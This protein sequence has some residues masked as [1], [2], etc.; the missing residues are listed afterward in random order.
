MVITQQNLT[1]ANK[2]GAG[3]LFVDPTN[4][5]NT[6]NINQQRLKRKA[7][8]DTV[9]VTRLEAS[10]V[11]NYKMDVCGDSCAVNQQDSGFFRI[12]GASREQMRLIWE[13]MKINGDRLFDINADAGVPISIGETDFAIVTEWSADGGE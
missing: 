12:S 13:T 5:D 8:K 1:F 11:K 2:N 3:V 6:L 4:V 10:V 7:G 9:K